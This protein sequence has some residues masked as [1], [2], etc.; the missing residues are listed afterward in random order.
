[1]VARLVL[2]LSIAA[3]TS[4]PPTELAMSFSRDGFY[5][6]PFPSDDLRTADGHIDLTKLPD[7]A[8]PSV[9]AQALALIAG[10]D[11]FAQT[12]AIYFRATA[13][14]D[15]ASL[16]D[17]AATTT[18]KASVFLV[19]VDP[20]REDFLRRRPI[21]VAV[22]DDGGP[23]GAPDLLALLPLQGVPL[24][25]GETYA[26][27]VTTGVRDRAG[28]AI[29][30]SPEMADLAAGRAPRGLGGD[31]LARYRMALGAVT[32]AR[33]DARSI[34]ALAV[35]TTQHATAALDV[36]RADAL[37][38]PLPQISPPVRGDVFA[39]YCVFDA[40][41]DMPVYQAGAPPYSSSGGAWAFDG[42]AS[43]SSITPRPHASGSR[44]RASRRR[45]MAGR[46]SCSC[47]AGVA[48]TAR[49]STAAR[50]PRPSSPRRSVPARARRASTRRSAL[51]GSWSMVR[52]AGRATQAA[53]TRSS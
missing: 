44:S 53:P 4:E 28:H 19:S 22:L 7:P 37:A 15:S 21:D 46:S 24:G 1:M 13:P 51:P 33:L 30:P 18:A 47:G 8:Q 6:A 50:V 2:V 36:V 29:G 5:D 26:A 10:A 35:F 16:P 31:A 25:A 39:D 9:M 14:L 17:L 32:S 45:P 27:V 12:G 23:F 42:T 52:S 38:R 40:H 41:I 48:A 34:A 20:S 11:G 49:W 43:R 3:C